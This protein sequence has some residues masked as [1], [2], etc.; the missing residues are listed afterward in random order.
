MSELNKYKDK[1][2]QAVI[3]GERVVVGSAE[4]TAYW[5]KAKFMSFLEDLY[6]DPTEQ[7]PLDLYG[8]WDHLPKPDKEYDENA[9]AE[10]Y[11]KN[12]KCESI[13]KKWGFINQ[14]HSVYR[15]LAQEYQD[16]LESPNSKGVYKDRF[17][18]SMGWINPETGEFSEDKTY[19]LKVKK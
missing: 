4:Y 8:N 9:C 18:K 15:Y 6:N 16:Y 10:Y 5:W 19:T 1:P 13:L 11:L 14:P 2:R 17:R 7:N 12:K 3:E